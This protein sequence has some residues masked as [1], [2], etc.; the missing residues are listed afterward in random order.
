MRLR[1][2]ITLRKRE[3]KS[4]AGLALE[5]ICRRA[6]LLAGE[7]ESDAGAGLS[8]GLDAWM[9]YSFR[10]DEGG[11][12]EGQVTVPDWRY[13]CGVGGASLRNSGEAE[14]WAGG[15]FRLNDLRAVVGTISSATCRQIRVGA[16]R[17]GQHRRDQREA[18]EE[19]QDEAEGTPH[20]VIVAS[21]AG[22]RVN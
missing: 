10:K 21:F 20:N 5:K 18:E 11:S 17:E 19:E 15:F 4:G 6:A 2:L 3:V 9:T 8:L 12:M 22:W 16:G 7:V 14:S 1:D 13:Y